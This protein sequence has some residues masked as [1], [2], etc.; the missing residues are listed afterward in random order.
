M[1]GVNNMAKSRS[2]SYLEDGLFEDRQLL[3]SSDKAQIQEIDISLLDDDPNNE[4]IYNMDG[5][6]ALAR[7]I[8]EEGV[9]DALRVYRMP[10]SNHYLIQSGHRRKKAAIIANLRTVPVIILDWEPDE[11]IR[12]RNLIT[13]NL[14]NRHKTPMTFARELQGYADTYKELSSQ[15]K[16]DQLSKLL[17]KSN[18]TLRRYFVLL[19]LIPELQQKVEKGL[20]LS[21]ISEARSMT[22]TQQNQ[23]NELI[24]SYEKAHGE[25]SLTK[26]VILTLAKQIKNSKK[27]TQTV[28]AFSSKKV[29]TLAQ[30]CEQ[31]ILQID[32]LQKNDKIEA[33]RYLQQAREIIDTYLNTL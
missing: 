6:E 26:E 13:C 4:K 1:K 23:F 9:R 25:S 32:T 28:S 12:Q 17:G 15:E 33:I 29:K 22:V 21:A 14:Y 20:S 10:N 11:N 18:A 27:K 30:K 8:K 16:L 3:K 19:D 2:S 7:S 31:A 24:D 5:M